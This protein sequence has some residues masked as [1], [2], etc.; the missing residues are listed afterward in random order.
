MRRARLT[1]TLAV[2]AAAV[3]AACVQPAHATPARSAATDGMV[4]VGFSIDKFAKRGN[5]LTA[6]G[7]V[8][9]T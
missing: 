5:G 1:V 8:V 2:A 4:H 6:V 3:V 7:K 9:A